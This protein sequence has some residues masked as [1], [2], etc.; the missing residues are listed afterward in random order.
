MSSNYYTKLTFPEHEY[1]FGECSDK[2]FDHCKH[3][4]ED[5]YFLNN[6]LMHTEFSD[7]GETVYIDLSNS[8]KEG[9]NLVEVTPHYSGTALDSVD[10]KVL[11]PVP[12]DISMYNVSS[13]K[14]DGFTSFLN[15]NFRALITDELTTG[16]QYM[17]L[18]YIDGVLEQP[19]DLKKPTIDMY[20][21]KGKDG[22]DAGEQFSGQGGDLVEQLIM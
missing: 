15:D 3:P 11:E 18:L 10:I 13:E 14:L 6:E 5:K 12:M 17:V 21:D 9:N 2:L 7:K 16:K 4:K 20:L 19:V 8:Y 1:N 22:G